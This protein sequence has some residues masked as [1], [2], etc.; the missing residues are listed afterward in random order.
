RFS[1]DVPGSVTMSAEMGR[2]ADATCGFRDGMLCLVGRA[3]QFGTRFAVLLSMTSDGGEVKEGGGKLLVENSNAVTLLLSCGTDFAGADPVEEALRIMHKAKDKSLDD[4]RSSHIS[5]HEELFGRVSLELGKEVSDSEE[6]ATDERLEKVRQGGEDTALVATFFDYGRYLLIASSRPHHDGNSLPANQ[7]GIWN[8]SLTPPWNSDFHTN[9]NIQMNYW[10]AETCSLPECHEPLF[11]WMR[12][13]AA[14]GERT[15]SA[16]YGCRGWVAHHISDPWGFSVPGDGAGCGLWPTGG[17]WLCDHLWEH[18]MFSGDIDFL[19]DTAWP[20][21]SGACRFFLDFLVEDSSGRLLCGPSLSPEN[22]YRLPDGKKGKLCMGPAMDNQILRELF[23]HALECAEVLGEEAPILDEMRSALPRL[24]PD[25]I[26][27]DGRLLEWA[28][29]YGEIEPG[30]RHVS[31]LWA[32]FPGSQITN[33]D[34]PELADA[35]RRVIAERLRHGGAHTGWSAAW[36]I[37]LL[38]HL[39]DPEGAHSMLLKMLRKCTHPNLFDNHPPFQIDGNFGAASGITEMLLQSSPGCLHVLPALPASWSDGYFRGLR[40]R[41]G[42][43]VSAKWRSRRLQ[44]LSL[45]S[46]REQT[47]S[48]RIGCKPDHLKIPLDKCSVFELDQDT[49]DTLGEV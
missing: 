18:Y 9:I 26:G 49:M 31:H 4:L 13:L 41:G 12:T 47:V 28:D 25:R 33:R 40:C 21:I 19:R 23:A 32:V 3:G 42:V 36:L 38:A 48:L 2:L 14:N 6:L 29:E 1:A 30:H 22:S 11:N 5:S 8:C 27:S 37:N 16:H 45:F 39:D 46:P 7:Q 17:A 24:P 44:Y 43:T 20:M 10:H 35:C 15:A 34:T